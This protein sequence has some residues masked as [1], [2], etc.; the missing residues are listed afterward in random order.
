MG[1]LYRCVGIRMLRAE[2]LEK[3]LRPGIHLPDIS[4]IGWQ[5]P[6]YGTAGCKRKA[7]K[8]KTRRGDTLWT[9]TF[10]DSMSYLSTNMFHASD[11]TYLF[12]I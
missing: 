1:T 11:D 2:L 9:K 12:E 7:N 5:F 3:G 6:P 8:N 4:F 10:P